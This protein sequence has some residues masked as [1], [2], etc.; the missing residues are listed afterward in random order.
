MTV[1]K[2]NLPGRKDICILE[3][4]IPP[5]KN[6]EI[7]GNIHNMTCDMEQ[8]HVLE[9]ICQIERYGIYL[10]KDKADIREAEI[11]VNI[12]LT[13]HD[14]SFRDALEIIRP[15]RLCLPRFKD[16]DRAEADSKNT[17]AL[18]HGFEWST[19]TDIRKRKK[20]SFTS[21]SRSIIIKVY[22]K[23]AEIISKSKGE[24]TFI[25]P[26]TRIE[27]LIKDKNEIPI[28]LNKKENLFDMQQED[29]EFAFHKLSNIFI[30]APLDV[31]YKK[32][33]KVIEEYFERIDVA[34]YAWRKNTVTELDNIIKKMD[35]FMI[36][37]ESE[38]SRYVS[39]IPAKSIKKNRSRIVKSLI[40]EFHYRN[41]SC[42]RITPTDTYNE[43]M[44]WM[45]SLTGSDAQNIMY[46]LEEKDK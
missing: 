21:S 32:M 36:I 11:N 34:M 13:A 14:H 30:K 42:V 28:Y 39:Y 25:S 15:F 2:C 5:L 43:L 10:R 40:E 24:I 17:V 12:Y 19:D 16:D 45:C 35:S 33:N 37:P 1:K 4:F 7:L 9:L 6:H 3:V 26:I 38:L 44:E 46:V 18:G 23:S 22:D 20:T 31:Y 41:A 29:V 8:T 27:F